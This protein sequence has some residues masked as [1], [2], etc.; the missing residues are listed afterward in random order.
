VSHFAADEFKELV[1]SRTDIV[2]LIAE[3]VTLQSQRGGREFAGL[4]PFHDDHNPSMRVY[5]ER[6][7]Y[8]CWSCGEGGDCFSFVMKR[9]NIGF[10]EALEML[11]Q[12]ANVELPRSYRPAGEQSA[13][14]DNKN[15]L[16]E[17]V[18]WAENEFHE[19]LLKSPLAERA[20]R[21]L[22]ER[23]I[24]GTSISRFRLGYHP[25]NW[26]WL[27]EKARGRYTPAEMETV[28]LAGEREGNNGF[29][30]YFVDRVMFPIRDAQKRPVAFGGR[31]LPD[32]RDTG[33]GKYFNSVDNVLF[34][35]SR[36]LYALDHARELISKSGTVVVTEGYTDCI[37]AH[38]HGLSNF[39]ATLGTALNETHVMN[40]K[41]LARRVV[42]VYD[43]D[44]P[45]QRATERAL[46][47]LLSH[48]IDLRILSLPDHL[49][50]A[51]FLAQRGPDSLISLLDH[52]PEAWDLKFRLLVER[53]GLESIDARHRVLTEMLETLSQVPAEAGVGLAASWQMREN[54]IVGQLSQRL[55]VSETHIRERLNDLRTAQQQKTGTA[56]AGHQGNAGG[57]SPN[58]YESGHGG[59]AS[60]P[61]ADVAESKQ[62]EMI[63]FPRNPSRDDLAA[64]DLL[65]ILFTTPEKTARVRGEI[66][67]EDIANPHLRELLGV[68][69]QMQ[70]QGVLPSYDRVSARLEDAGLKN[71]AV[72]IDLYGR[73]VGMSES[74]LE[75]T[76][77]YF[78]H[79]REVAARGTAELAGPHLSPSSEKLDQQ[80][81]ERLKQATE[82]HR[83]R[84]SR[85][86]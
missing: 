54:V 27:I 56:S 40:L 57:Q 16:Y 73:D 32:S 20:R 3:S 7:S 67:F 11:A 13:S 84:V 62:V 8:K 50:P 75:K 63:H 37:M 69:F 9:E 34:H 83:K 65:A 79:C 55:K 45:G 26:Q 31:I 74:L 48:E 22:K 44:G 81:R 42:L 68:C 4:C 72:E 19:C 71:L 49:D 14:R 60:K 25:D 59:A 47:K 29:Y 12:R 2:N 53:H 38:Q 41:R 85:T 36:L 17:I 66:G 43:G 24:S 1:R 52:A 10:R 21:Y 18:A 33:M 6:Q 77:G 61:A 51:D 5:P 39:V 70:D 35:K 80:G 58:S 46:P 78:R 86:T 28:K 64:R 23:G 15:R 76:L 82:L 30:D